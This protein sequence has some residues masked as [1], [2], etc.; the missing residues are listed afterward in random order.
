MFQ[1]LFCLV[2]VGQDDSSRGAIIEGCYFLHLGNINSY[3]KI[4]LHN[5]VSKTDVARGISPVWREE[6]LL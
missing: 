1:W 4:I 3:V 6:F 2:F 5:A